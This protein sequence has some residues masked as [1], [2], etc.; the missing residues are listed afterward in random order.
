MKTYNLIVRNHRNIDLVIEN[1]TNNISTGIRHT[2]RLTDRLSGVDISAAK[3]ILVSPAL[4]T[5]TS[6]NTTVH[7]DKEV[8]VAKNDLQ[9]SVQVRANLRRDS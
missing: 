8:S 1:L 3:N 4:I 7:L 6:S 5:I 9:L 2:L